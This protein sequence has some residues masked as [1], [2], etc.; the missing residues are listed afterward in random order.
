MVAKLRLFSLGLSLFFILY[1]NG[2]GDGVDGNAF[3]FV[4]AAKD[5]K[6]CGVDF[7]F[8]LVDVDG[9]GYLNDIVFLD[10]DRDF[11]DDNLVFRRVRV[12]LGNNLLIMLYFLMQM[13]QFLIF[14]LVGFD[15]IGYLYFFG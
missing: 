11:L 13:R 9:Y 3:L 2:V 15:K 10:V 1:L 7:L 14:L 12:E 5:R 4:T 6:R 8:F